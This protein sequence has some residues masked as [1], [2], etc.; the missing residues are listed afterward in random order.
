[1]NSLFLLAINNLRERKLRSWL[2]VLGIIIGI[3]AIVT[4]I[5]LGEGLENAIT[6]QFEKMG[7][8]SIRI[9]PGNLRGPPTGEIG[10]SDDIVD[11]VESVKEVEYVDAVL[12]NFATIKY[13]NEELF[14]YTVGYDTR[15]SDKGFLDTDLDVDEG[16]L[17]RLGD[18][19]VAIIG[20]KIANDKFKKKINIKNNIEIEGRK[21]KVIGIF[22][23]TGTELD[24]RIYLPLETSREIFD[25][26]GVVNALVVKIREGLDIEKAADSIRRR[27]ERTMDENEFT[28]YTPQQLLDQMS[29]ILDAIKIILSGVAAISI[30]VGAVGIMNSMFTSVLQRTRQIGVMKAVG[31]TRKDILSLFLFESGLIGLGGGLIGV[32]IGISLAKLVEVIAS[33]LGYALLVIRLDFVIIISVLLFAFVVGMIS[34]F[35]PAYQASKLVPVDALRYE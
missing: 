31:A 11:K 4:L 32:I 25:S 3:A 12:L 7:I 34:G 27:L 21:V 19:G 22:E 16:R 30:I 2:T 29:A 17:F 33:N 5:F 1:M 15:L 6:F 13:S 20:Y 10:F 14:F 24:N 9:T 18:K 23:N 35:I 26:Y 28:V 8:S